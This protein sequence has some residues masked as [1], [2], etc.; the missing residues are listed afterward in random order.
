MHYTLC[1]CLEWSQS[2]HSDWLPPNQRLVDT[3]RSL[4]TKS[5]SHFLTHFRP[6][7]TQLVCVSVL[8]SSDAPRV[9]AELACLWLRHAPRVSSHF[10]VTYFLNMG[11]AGNRTCS[12]PGTA[13]GRNELLVT[14]N[15]SGSGNSRSVIKMKLSPLVGREGECTDR[16]CVRAHSPFLSALQKELLVGGDELELGGFLPD[17]LQPLPH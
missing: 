6:T 4:Y 17:P 5:L 3:T 8:L 12:H 2:L 9:P 7:S 1:N 16:V 11:G 13:V 15:Q 10:L 14:R